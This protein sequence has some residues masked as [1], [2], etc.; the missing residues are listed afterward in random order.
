MCG[1]ADAGPVATVVQDQV[2][3]IADLASKLETASAEAAV[4]AG[5]GYVTS[6]LSWAD[7]VEE[8]YAVKP[9][10]PA[11]AAPPPAPV[12]DVEHESFEVPVVQRSPPH[13][14]IEHTDENASDSEDELLH[15]AT[16]RTRTL[17]HFL[18]LCFG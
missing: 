15:H 3:P 11:A 5:F 6:T 13:A 2:S 4:F 7:Q 8:A 18:P 10:A 12:D 1:D 16:S 17:S 9:P 14:V